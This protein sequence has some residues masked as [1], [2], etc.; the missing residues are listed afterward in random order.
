MAR[1]VELKI[2]RMTLTAESR[3]I[4]AEEQRWL[5]RGRQ[6]KNYNYDPEPAY[7]Q[8][9][10]LR[11]HRAL[12]V[13]E[14]AR[15]LHLA[16][17]YLKG[18]PYNQVESH[19]TYTR[20]LERAQ[21]MLVLAE[22]IAKEVARFGSGANMVVKHEHIKTWME[23]GATAQQMADKISEEMAVMVAVGGPK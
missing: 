11:S 17:A 4:R 12:V 7:G 1:L 10:R 3:L 22:N 8:Y 23:G 14:Y 2:K 13:R 18:R 9:N 20:L 5:R 15:V 19:A 16:H 6:A 21:F